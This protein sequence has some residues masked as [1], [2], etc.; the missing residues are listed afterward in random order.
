VKA[1]D[2]NDPDDIR[3]LFTEDASYF[4]EPHAQPW[5]GHRQI[6]REWLDRKDEP[7]EYTFR[8]EV[9]AMDG[10]LGFVRGWTE[11]VRYDPPRQYGNLWVIRLA[12]DGRASEYT[13]WYVRVRDATPA[14][15][16]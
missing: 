7:Q 2:S 3:A 5:T 9:L 12:E 4:T 10:N 8:W 6:V 13:E 1:W 15:P 16:D 11:Y 14:F